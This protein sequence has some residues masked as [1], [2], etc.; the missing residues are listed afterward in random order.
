ML[1]ISLAKAKA[2]TDEERLTRRVQ[3]QYP[4]GIRL[5][6]EYWPVGGEYKAITIAE[7]ES[8]APVMATIGDWSDVFDFTVIPAVSL[9]QGLQFAQQM[10]R[11]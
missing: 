11:G 6:G 3:W 5:V 1:F 4:E 8:I 2:G 9:E 10:Q 7:A